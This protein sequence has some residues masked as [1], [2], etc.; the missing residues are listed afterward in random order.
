MKYAWTRRHER[1]YLLNA[2]LDVLSASE[3]GYTDWRA[4]STATPW[5]SLPRPEALI[6]AIHVEFDGA[7]GAPRMTREITARGLPVSRERVRRLIPAN[8]IRAGHKRRYKATTN[9]AQHLPVAENVLNRKFQTTAPDRVWKANI[10]YIP[11]QKGGRT[12]RW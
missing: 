1:A 3:S 9:S 4:G 11:T 2:M 7:Y 5:L 6:R 8:G 12:W 10:T